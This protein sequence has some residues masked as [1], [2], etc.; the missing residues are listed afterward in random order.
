MSDSMLLGAFEA[1]SPEGIERALA[2]GV[3]PIDPIKGRKPIEHLIEVYLRSPRFADCLQVMLNAGASIDDP[4]LEAMRLDDSAKLR[5]LTAESP[6][7]LGQKLNLS[8]AFTS[9]RGVTVLHVCSEFN[10]V[11]LCAPFNRERRG[12]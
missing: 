8:T 2:A 6:D 1:H 5:Q 7:C 10:S 11:K 4:L 12:R 3:S 9:C